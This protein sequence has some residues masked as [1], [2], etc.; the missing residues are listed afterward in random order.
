VA[1]VIEEGAHHTDLMFGN[2]ADPPSLIE[3]RRQELGYL[4]GWLQEH[5]HK[6]QMLPAREAKHT[7]S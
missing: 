2:P 7:S 1:V 5:A 4:T 6:Q 3:A